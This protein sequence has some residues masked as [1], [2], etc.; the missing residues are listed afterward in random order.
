M[1]F[2]TIVGNSAGISTGSTFRIPSWFMRMKYDR[3]WRSLMAPTFAARMTKACIATFHRLLRSASNGRD[4]RRRSALISRA[5]IKNSA[6]NRL[7]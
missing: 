5:G 7:A 1:T 2:G 3:F 4:K 6:A